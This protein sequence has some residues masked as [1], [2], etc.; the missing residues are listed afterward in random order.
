MT[1]FPEPA[2]NSL[3]LRSIQCAAVGHIDQHALRAL[4][5]AERLAFFIN[6]GK[7]DKIREGAITRLVCDRAN[8]SSRQ[9]GKIEVLREFSFFE[10]E[11]KISERVLKSLNGAK[12]DGRTLTVQYSEKRKNSFRGGR[13]K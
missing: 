10:V 4:V 6:V 2:G 8:V 1:G 5:Q 3:T 12:L 7:L 9:I 11:T 13:R